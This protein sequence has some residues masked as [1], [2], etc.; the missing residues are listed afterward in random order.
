MSDLCSY[1]RR[2]IRA[3][4]VPRRCAEGLFCLWLNS[5]SF[6]LARGLRAAVARRL[7]MLAAGWTLAARQVI[8]ER[9]P[10][11]ECLS[12]QDADPKLP[13]ALSEARLYKNVLLLNCIC[14]NASHFHKKIDECLGV[15]SATVTSTSTPGAMLMEVI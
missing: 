1:S 9:F 13:K 12:T 11:A 15:Y 5:A 14:F 6:M 2:C 3:C 10:F 4:S 7:F 8:S